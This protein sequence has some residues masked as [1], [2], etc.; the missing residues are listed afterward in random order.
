MSKSI[1][2]LGRLF[3]RTQSPLVAQVFA[4]AIGQP[5]LVHP[6][7][8]EQIIGGYMRGA[9]E[10]RPS[11]LVVGELSPEARSPTGAVLTPARRV[12]VLN[13]S[14]AL[15]NR[16]EG[17]FCEPG[18]L[19]YQ[20]LRSS[21]DS[22]RGDAS[23]EAIVFRIET[24]G[25]M[26]SGL[27]DFTD[28]VY[29]TRGQKPLYACIDDY[30]YSAGYG[31]AAACDQIWITRTGGAGS[32]G[33]IGY[34]VDQS[35]WDAKVGIKITHIFSG[36]HKNDLS[37]HAPLP[38]EQRDWLQQ[39]M[40]SMRGLFAESVAR[41]RGMDVAAVLAT[42][43]QVYQGQAAIDVGFA[44]RLGTYHQLM[45]HIAA[46][47]AA[48][49][50]T[51][52]AAPAASAASAASNAAALAPAAAAAVAAADAKAA[53]ISGGDAE[54]NNDVEAAGMAALA[55]AEFTAAVLEADMP[56]ALAT[57]LLRRGPA[58]QDATAAIS[59]ARGVRDVCFAAGL[60]STAPDYVKTNTSIDTIRTQLLAAKAAGEAVL[61]TTHPAGAA[62]GAA[63]PG[64]WGHT[65]QKFGG[66]P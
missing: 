2:L 41:Y 49:D 1:S 5:L 27:F 21:Y 3:G 24:P 51:E 50:S 30:A 4:N 32:V 47:P 17:G 58:N 66:T 65:I 29:A 56:S 8:G 31:L 37:P 14:G 34:H 40:D 18:P 23:I 52:T 33:V 60:E 62:G 6:T 25:G 39:R 48:D 15:V 9:V 20:E 12:A 63:A 54:P 16:Y 57:A 55:L 13:I 36:A 26:G 38:D 35:G 53:V 11:T 46:G 19:S 43:A 45:E 22:V 61:V 42:E 44:D 10:A 64:A 7:M 28:H 59:Y